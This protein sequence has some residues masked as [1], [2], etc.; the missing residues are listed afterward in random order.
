MTVTTPIPLRTPTTLTWIKTALGDFTAFL[1]DHAACERKASAMAMSLVCHYPDRPD[2]VRLMTDLAIEELQHFKQVM[3]LLQQ[4]DTI[5]APD[6]KDPYIN[7]LIKQARHGSTEF[8]L[9]RLMLASVI[10]TRGCERFALIGQ[11]H[12]DD[13]MKKFYQAF[14]HAEER[15]SLI[16]VDIAKNYFEHDV[17]D[18]RLD[19]LLTFE[20]ELIQTIPLRAAVH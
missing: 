17:V 12:P 2:I 20:G 1:Q 13:D 4:R 8:M 7:A 3:L 6:T 18:Q 11:H 19:E 14:A 16:F 10:E 9:D 15:H 5:L